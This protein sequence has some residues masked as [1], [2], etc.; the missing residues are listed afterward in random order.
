MKEQ[1][2]HPTPER[3]EYPGLAQFNSMRWLSIMNGLQIDELLRT[4]S[5][6]PFVKIANSETADSIVALQLG[7]NPAYPLARVTYV[8]PKKGDTWFLTS[9]GWIRE[10]TNFSSPAVREQYVEYNA[11]QN[12][13]ERPV[14]TLLTPEESAELDRHGIVGKGAP[15]TTS[16]ADAFS[17]QMVQDT[18][19][20]RCHA[21]GIRAMYESEDF[22]IHTAELSIDEADEMDEAHF[23][24]E[25][26][27]ILSVLPKRT[28]EDGHT[29]IYVEPLLMID[30]DHEQNTAAIVLPQHMSGAHSESGDRSEGFKTLYYFYRDGVMHKL[31]RVATD[32][33]A[34]IV[35]EPVGM[36]SRILSGEPVE[37]AAPASATE[38]RFVG[39]YLSEAAKTMEQISSLLALVHKLPRQE[40][41]VYRRLTVANQRKEYSVVEAQQPDKTTWTYM[42]EATNNPNE[43][44]SPGRFIG[45]TRIDLFESENPDI[46]EYATALKIGYDARYRN[47]GVFISL[48]EGP[49]DQRDTEGERIKRHVRTTSNRHLPNNETLPHPPFT[50][51]GSLFSTVRNYGSLRRIVSA[52]EQST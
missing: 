50:T 1:Q 48:L 24:Y 20:Q 40:R 28:A 51:A 17:R 33:K 41:A 47:V 34:I 12:L 29:T 7:Y 8:S 14:D 46:P 19:G 11:S 52:L 2:S 27:N 38:S 32:K 43:K 4:N 16:E 45:E 22:E 6:E 3:V 5:Q 31:E 37:H 18:F 36:F 9:R 25:C 39:E 26:R 44:P 10:Q 13:A 35:G 23:T 30:V 15:V 49:R 42:R 21:R